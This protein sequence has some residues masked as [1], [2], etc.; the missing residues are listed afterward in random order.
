MPLGRL[1]R[2][3]AEPIRRSIRRSPGSG[4]AAWR[5]P[6]DARSVIVACP[7]A[8]EAAGFPCWSFLAET[9]GDAGLEPTTPGG[10][11]RC[12]TSELVAL[13][14]LRG[15]E[16]PTLRFPGCSTAELQTRPV[17]RG[18][19]SPQGGARQPGLK[20]P[21][22]MAK[23]GRIDREHNC[24]GSAR[25]CQDLAFRKCLTPS[26]RLGRVTG[27]QA[28]VA[29]RCRRVISTRSPGA[30][31]SRHRNISDC[32]AVRFTRRRA[33]STIWDT[34]TPEPSDVRDSRLAVSSK[35]VIDWGCV[36]NSDR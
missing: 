27:C 20:E 29:D 2:V 15:V 21:G 33:R 9:E 17:I 10:T 7:K 5:Y 8:G 25:R 31:R 28:L 4:F 16:P 26:A 18:T 22:H 12:S 24:G 3:A 30:T 13:V 34:A 11:I 14:D 23:N 6:R 35:S 36:P 19:H 32:L 1:R